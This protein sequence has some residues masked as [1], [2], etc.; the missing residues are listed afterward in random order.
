MRLTV[1][2]VITRPV[3]H[4][5]PAAGGTSGTSGTPQKTQQIVCPTNVPPARKTWDKTPRPVTDCPTSQPE[6]GHRWDAENPG[7]QALS[8]LSHVSHPESSNSANASAKQ[9]DSTAGSRQ[10]EVSRAWAAAYGRL[11]ANYPEGGRDTLGRIA[12]ALLGAWDN[13]EEAAEAAS[14]AYVAD[15]THGA[16]FEATLAT[17]EGA[18]AEAIRHLATRCHDCGKKTTVTVLTDYGARY[19]PRC[20]SDGTI[21]PHG[22]GTV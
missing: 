22:G 5:G 10:A 18:V 9:P 8:H 12:P 19:C 14:V 16:D 6:V 11:G 3:V 13:A 17:W 1:L 15:E 4:N 21:Y 7:K 20:L 2:D